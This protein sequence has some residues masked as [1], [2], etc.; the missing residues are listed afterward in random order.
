MRT[1]RECA[2]LHAIWSSSRLS[3]APSSRALNRSAP[4]YTASAPLA[5]A[6]R[7]ASSD[8]AGERSSGMTFFL[9]TFQSSNARVDN[10]AAAAREL[11]QTEHTPE[12]ASHCALGERSGLSLYRVAV[13]AC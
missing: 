13:R 10:D 9:G 4:R 5:T 7:T 11:P 2:S 3:C 1:P 6:A 12:E 8:P